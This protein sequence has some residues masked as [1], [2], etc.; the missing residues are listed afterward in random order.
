MLLAKHA[1]R[2]RIP[3]PKVSK[4]QT[5]ATN[6]RPGKR[7]LTKVLLRVVIV[8]IVLRIQDRKLKGHLNAF[9]VRL[10][11]LPWKEVLCAAIV[12]LGN[13]WKLRAR[14]KRFV[15][16]VHRAIT[17]IHPTRKRAHNAHVGMLNRRRGKRRVRNAVLVNSTMRWVL[18]NAN[19]V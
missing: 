17:R 19:R 3:R 11:V 9:H 7:T 2:V 10:V 14:A 16:L 18:T 13:L 5:I 8:Q 1:R 15:P 4:V 12:S 6:A